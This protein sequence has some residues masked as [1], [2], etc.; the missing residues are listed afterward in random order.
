MASCKECFHKDVCN[1]LRPIEYCLDKTCST[2]KDHSTVKEVIYGEWIG[3]HGLG[4]YDDYRC[5]V[6]DMYE[7]GTRNPNLLGKYCSYCGATLRGTST[8]VEETA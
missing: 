3:R 4:G 7:E 8:S 2:F 1:K 6:C 5:S